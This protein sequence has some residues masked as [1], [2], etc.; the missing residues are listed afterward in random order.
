MVGSEQVSPKEEAWRVVR[1]EH[2][3]WRPRTCEAWAM[4]VRGPRAGG[5]GHS[6]GSWASDPVRVPE[7]SRARRAHQADDVR[8]EARPPR[9][10]LS[11][12]PVTF[13]A[14]PSERTHRRKTACKAMVCHPPGM[15][16]CS[17]AQRQGG[18]HPGGSEGRPIRHGS[19]L[20]MD[21]EEGQSPSIT[22]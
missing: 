6:G 2:S 17:E 14:G 16:T 4:P 5:G 15:V 18:R 19:K 12:Q 13:L 9:R 10:L 11:I 1:I 20:G 3:Q 22:L 7:R 8:A 21:R